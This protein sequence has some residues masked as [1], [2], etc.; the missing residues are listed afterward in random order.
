LISKECFAHHVKS[1]LA[2]YYDP[3][4]LQ[5]SPLLQLAGMTPLAAEQALPALRATLREA[6]EALRP[7]ASLP[8]GRPEW[9]GYRILWGRYIES[10][11]LYDVA[12]DLA[13]SRPSFYR[14]HQQ[15]IEA[16]VS[17]LW[18]RHQAA[19]HEQAPSSSMEASP[20]ER[21]RNEAV[22]LARAAQRQAV[23]LHELLEGVNQTL[24]SLME[25]QG[26]QL[27]I[28]APAH[29][30]VVY[31]DPAMLRQAV[32]NILT[33]ATGLALEKRL[34]LD[35]S[36]QDNHSIWR[37]HKLAAA[38]L[39]EADIAEVGGMAVGRALLQEYGG[40]LWLEK[41]GRAALTLT[42]SI[43]VATPQKILVIDDDGDT[44]TLYSRYL[45][46]HHY[47]ALVARDGEQLLETLAEN[48]P[49][50]ILLDVLMPRED[51]WAILQRLKTTP[52][53]ACIPVVICSVL[54]QPR[55]ALALG[56]AEVLR[57]PVTEETLLQA[58]R[59]ALHQGGSAGSGS[60]A[61]PESNARP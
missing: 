54:S 31:G 45:Q 28:Q 42:F 51:G 15:A 23:D 25:R 38:S 41:V 39:C 29:L 24:S 26:I 16:L 18:S 5:N 35:V 7:D 60:L 53:T 44:I 30:P 55:L 49:D 59:R 52:E 32:L 58:V 27:S 19:L 11:S 17:I 57:K 6:I 2:G 14:H 3:V 12:G 61:A 40:R 22:K 10:R 33:E 34:E 56:A 43:P 8:Y 37:L 47:V 9:L 4:A 21:A 50:L 48:Q 46:A 1:A 13:L 36:L 20:E